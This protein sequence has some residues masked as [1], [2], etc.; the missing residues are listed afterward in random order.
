M[1]PMTRAALNATTAV[2][3]LSNGDGMSVRNFGALRGLIPQRYQG[4]LLENWT[5]NVNASQ[6]DVTFNYT[7]SYPARLP[8][9]LLAGAKG[10]GKT[11][12]A[13]VVANEV[14]RRHGKTAAFWPCADLMD[15]YYATLKDGADET[16]EMID[17]ELR[18]ADV[19][20]LDD[21]G[22]ENGTEFARSRLF[23]IVDERYR[24]FRPLV[25]TTNLAPEAL[26]E[27]AYDRMRDVRTCTVVT[28]TENQR[29]R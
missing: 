11:H 23:R 22:A 4:V 3:R 25:V 9:L 15:R 1:D 10:G 16:V 28:F 20:I 18:G 19:L 14:V 6:R 21:Y 7:T 8:W 24:L 29:R 12:M 26:D 13:C 2:A 5:T 17:Q 27:R